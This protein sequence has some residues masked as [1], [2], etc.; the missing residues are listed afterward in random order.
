M[1]PNIFLIDHHSKTSNQKLLKHSQISEFSDVPSGC[2]RGTLKF[3]IAWYRCA[4]HQNP[5]PIKNLTEH[6][7]FSCC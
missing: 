1:L 5:V 2:V 3:I 6:N 7:P 4:E